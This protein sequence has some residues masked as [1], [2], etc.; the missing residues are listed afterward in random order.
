MYRYYKHRNHLGTNTIYRFRG[1]DNS[2]SEYFSDNPVLKP[3]WN[4]ASGMI[5]KENWIRISRQAARAILP[6][7]FKNEK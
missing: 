3:R 4:F 1:N 5:V 7:A 6:Q 2:K